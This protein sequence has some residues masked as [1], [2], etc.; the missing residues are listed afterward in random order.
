MP[1]TLRGYWRSGRHREPGLRARRAREGGAQHPADRL[2]DEA[3]APRTRRKY[4]MSQAGVPME[5][6]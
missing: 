5:T 4:T 3:A 1:S 2:P 6:G